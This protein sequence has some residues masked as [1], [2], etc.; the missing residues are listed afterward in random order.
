MT[1]E[2]LDLA[3]ARR[4]AIAAQ[5]L[6]RRR[7]S[8]VSADDIARTV[9]A[10]GLLQLDFVNAVCPSHYLVVYSRLGAYPLDLFDAAMYRSGAFTEQWAHE[11]SLVPMDAWPLLRYRRE[12]HKARPWGFDDI[13][14]RHHPY[15]ETVMAAIRQRGPLCAADLPD[16]THTGRKLPESW[17][18]TVPRAVLEAN[19][20]RGHLAVTGRKANFT[21]VFDLAER[22]IPHAF[23]SSQ[24]PVDDAHR[25]L[26]LR[27]ARCL[28]IGTLADI[29]DYF[30]MPVHDAKPRVLE[31]V[32]RGD[33]T[34]VSVAGW[35]SPAYLAG[36]AVMKAVAARALLSPFD[37]L[38]WFRPRTRRLF[39]FDYRFEVFTP[40]H[41]R[42][43]GT[44]VLPFLLD[45]GLAARVDVK[46]DR[47]RRRLDVPG[48]YLEAAADPARVADALAQELHHL[49]A[50]LGLETV[51]VG[52][53][54]NLARALRDATRTDRTPRARRPQ[55]TRGGRTGLH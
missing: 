10:M 8:R 36:P 7:P 49:A 23:F 32:E 50:W 29:A 33:L 54:G 25:E 30:R 53:R 34:P 21:R 44:Y 16:P 52:R 11:A 37:P 22:V 35:T 13:V 27:A 43:W 31:L 42:R 5:G 51:A 2:S 1:A 46:A 9:R 6:A 48:A 38:V 14:A 55:K 4:L 28:G 39:A 3:T 12:T 47:T 41:Q 15:F 18:G 40:R 45:D 24:I 26:L 17:Y 20:G 19:F